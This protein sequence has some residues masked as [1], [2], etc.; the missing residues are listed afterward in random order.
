M[1][2]PRRHQPA[3]P[4]RITVGELVERG[5][6]RHPDAV[7]IVWVDSDVLVCRTHALE[8]VTLQIMSQLRRA[9]DL[10]I[11]LVGEAQQRRGCVHCAL[12]EGY[13]RRLERRRR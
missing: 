7:A 3:E 13:R 9:T 6:D 4:D 5:L 11:V 12:H 8:P 10:A 1:R 2:I